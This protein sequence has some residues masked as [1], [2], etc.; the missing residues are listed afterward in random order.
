VVRVLALRFLNVFG[1]VK[2]PDGCSAHANP[3]HSADAAIHSLSNPWLLNFSV[4]QFSVTVRTTVSGAPAG[5]VATPRGA[6]IIVANRESDN[7]SVLNAT[8]LS[9]VATL[10]VGR[11]PFALTV[12]PDAT[13]VYVANVQSATIS[14]ISTETLQ[15]VASVSV[16]HMPYGVA[17]S[18][19][20][21]RV[22]V[23]SQSSGTVSVIDSTSLRVLTTEKV[24]RFPEGVI[25][26]PGGRKAYVANWFSG[27]V[28]VVEIATGTE[29]K[30]IQTGGG[31]RTL[32]VVPQSEGRSSQ[33]DGARAG[34][35]RH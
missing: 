3:S 22:L 34:E 20:G 24:G 7:V 11:A 25:V 16:G 17:T 19:D 4:R 28:S 12:S 10:P 21:A 5:I 29:L 32:A 31:S 35:R 26:D 27:D 6:L 18:I 13:R 2:R 30:R 8:A 15:T 23:A 1:V 33:A 14:V 9:V